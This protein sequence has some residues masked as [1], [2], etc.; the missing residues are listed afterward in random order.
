MQARL[1]VQAWLKKFVLYGALLCV[2]LAGF[3]LLYAPYLPRLASEGFPQ[4]DWPAPGDYVTVDGSGKQGAPIPTDLRGAVFDV[5]GRRLFEEKDGKAL[6]IFQGG[7]LRFEHYAE[8]FDSGSRFNSYSMIKSLIGA[9]VLKA[10]AEGK[11]KS[12][13]D[14]VGIEPV[15]PHLELGVRIAGERPLGLR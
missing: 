3:A 11:I 8:G 2:A 15:V 7:R 5:K 13:Q 4:A 6:L 14:P 1:K 9:L 12:L 10:E